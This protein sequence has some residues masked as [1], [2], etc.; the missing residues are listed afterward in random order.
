VTTYNGVQA[1]LIF[2]P[3]ASW[4]HP[5]EDNQGWLPP[6]KRTKG[7]FLEGP[8]SESERNGRSWAVSGQVI[9]DRSYQLV[10]FE[11]LVWHVEQEPRGVVLRGL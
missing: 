10:D 8:A 7:G 2:D 4:Q 6:P 11:E 9:D 3:G 5:Q 1:V